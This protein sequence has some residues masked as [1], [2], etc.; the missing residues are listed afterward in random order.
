MSL[1]KLLSSIH[2]I[3][4]RATSDDRIGFSNVT[5][6]ES[7]MAYLAILRPLDDFRSM[8]HFTDSNWISELNS[9]LVRQL[10]SRPFAYYFCTKGS[11][12]VVNFE[13]RLNWI[14]KPE[15]FGSFVL[16]MSTT[17]WNISKQKKLSNWEW[18]RVQS[19][20]FWIK[21]VFFWRGGYERRN[22]KKQCF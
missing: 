8:T 16:S 9:F 13:F 21:T 7:P 18:R 4:K 11:P 1:T 19:L 6:Q 22:F 10:Q 12:I 2:V 20:S 3:M 15:E 17:S 14:S 5:G